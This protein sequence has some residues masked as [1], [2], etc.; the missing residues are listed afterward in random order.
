MK[1]FSPMEASI[2]FKSFVYLSVFSRC[3]DEIF[4]S[5]GSVDQI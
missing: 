5:D 4:L 3:C 1:S 2:K